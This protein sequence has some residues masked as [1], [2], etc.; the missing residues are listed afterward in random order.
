[1]I[2]SRVFILTA[3]LFWIT[4]GATQERQR[5]PRGVAT[6]QDVATLQNEKLKALIGN[7]TSHDH[8]GG[9]HRAGYNGVL[10]LV[11]PD[12]EES[13]YV[14]AYAGFNL[15]H[16]FDGR[17]EYAKREI[18][19][20]PRYSAMNLR[21]IDDLTVELHQ[22]PT[23]EFGVES[24]TRFQLTDSGHLDF[25]FRCVPRKK[26]FVGGFFGVFWASY[27]NAPI[28]KSIYFLDGASSLAKPTWR[29][30]CTQL[31]NR[32]ST[33][34]HQDSPQS[35]PFAKTGE[36][37]F[38]GISP[39]RY[40]EPFFYGRFRDMVLI[41]LFRPHPNLRFTHSPSGG[42]RTPAGDDSNPAW[43]FQL[44][45]P[46]PVIDREYK[47]EGRLVYKEWKGRADVLEEVRKYL[48]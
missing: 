29:Q 32:D 7:N 45:V 31:H 20:E 5:D 39:L 3:S 9:N 30:F 25:T 36:T 13:P 48:E 11:N 28:D 17:A 4:P 15:E 33:V 16:Y 43:D 40:S 2:P 46:K 23:S 41:Y 21:R 18:F 24:W 26:N 42:G 12:E 44:I 8:P 22:P 6:E 47:L 34:L 14:P 1:M 19:F 27:M 38:T 35:L 37:L 10:S